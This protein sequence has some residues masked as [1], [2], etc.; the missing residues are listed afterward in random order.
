MEI[1]TQRV[2][3]PPRLTVMCDKVLREFKL[4]QGSQWCVTRLLHCVTDYCCSWT[5]AWPHT[6]TIEV[7]QH[8]KLDLCKWQGCR[9]WPAAGVL[10]TTNR[11][12][13]VRWGTLSRFLPQAPHASDGA[14][15]PHGSEKLIP[16]PHADQCRKLITSR[17]SRA[18]SMPTMIGRRPSPHLWVILLTNRTNDHITHQP[19][20]SN[21]H[22]TKIRKIILST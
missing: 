3:T 4:H 13:A 1:C 22:I 7:K 6:P 11:L 10:V 16:Y 5:K 17:G 18:L 20:Q 15:M 2:Q 9:Q 14:E 12:A 8:R 21:K 19:W